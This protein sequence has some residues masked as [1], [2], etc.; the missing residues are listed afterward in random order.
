MSR[1][2]LLAAILYLAGTSAAEAHVKWF[3]G[4]NEAEILSQPKPELFTHLC[5]DNVIP[6]GCALVL[7]CVTIAIGRHFKNCKFNKSLKDLCLKFEPS[8]NLF[9]RLCMGLFLVYCAASRTLLAPNLIICAHCPQW[10]PYAEYFA[11][12]SILFGVFSR[13]GALVLL[14]L[15]GFTFVKHTLAD[16]LDLLPVYGPAI[17]FAL[18]GGGRYSVDARFS[19]DIEPSPEAVQLGHLVV[20]TFT[21]V[22][23]IVLALDE[24][25]LHPQLALALLKHAP[26]LNFLAGMHVPDEKFVLYI[27]LCELLLGFVILVGSLPRL[28]VLALVSVFAVT[29]IMFG[30]TELFGHMPYY[31][32]IASILI[33][34][35]GNAP[36]LDVLRR[37]SALLIVAWRTTLVKW[38]FRQVP[39]VK[40]GAWR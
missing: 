5:A 27:G 4:R 15:F 30:T 11:G 13:V 32:V 40:I 39:I 29:T 37:S 35:A 2:P 31:A 26:A 17:Y 21:G 19:F 8:I 16:C 1:G 9:M 34:G 7:L 24:K 38:P 22:G 23:L 36:A 10:L 18:A 33:Y 20:R 3:L 12:L 28:A 6:I 25:L 14:G